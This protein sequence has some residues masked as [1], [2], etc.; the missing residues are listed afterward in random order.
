MSSRK[1]LIKTLS[2]FDRTF[3]TTLHDDL[4]NSCSTLEAAFARELVSRL[5]DAHVARA[6]ASAYEADKDLSVRRMRMLLDPIRL[7]SVLR[8]AADK[9]GIPMGELTSQFP[10]TA[11]TMETT[12][13]SRF[14]EF[15]LWN[16]HTQRLELVRMEWGNH[17]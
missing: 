17:G 3:A 14:V 12:D 6:F 8:L 9:L 13:D 11:W 5:T 1:K 16:C 7:P 4:V 10:E 2:A 15:Q